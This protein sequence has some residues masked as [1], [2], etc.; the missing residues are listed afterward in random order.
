MNC[1]GRVL[2]LSFLLVSSSEEESFSWSLSLVLGF[3]RAEH[4][5]GIGTAKMKWRRLITTEPFA[6]SLCECLA[7]LAHATGGAG[8]LASWH[9][10]ALVVAT[11]PTADHLATAYEWSTKLKWRKHKFKTILSRPV[12]SGAMFSAGQPKMR[13]SKQSPT[14]RGALQTV[15]TRL[16]REWITPAI[17][18]G[19]P[20]AH[21]QP[22]AIVST[23]HCA[24]IQIEKNQELS[25]KFMEISKKKQLS[26]Q[27]QADLLKP[28]MK[29]MKLLFLKW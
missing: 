7:F 18:R 8:A 2:S 1:H 14:A 17:T 10:C 12:S 4:F 20:C 3:G 25:R 21:Q 9:H 24:V 16:G 19:Q 29:I 27:I 11:V 22:A 23:W 15:P 5:I 28:G 6:S 26:R 13:A